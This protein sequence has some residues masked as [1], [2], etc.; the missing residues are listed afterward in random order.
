MTK[1]LLT[2]PILALLACDPE[3]D[4]DIEPRDTEVVATKIE[5]AWPI[6]KII[7]TCFAT[8]EI[9][10]GVASLEVYE[11]IGDEQAFTLAIRSAA[12]PKQVACVWNSLESGLP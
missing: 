1:L 3:A 2:L 12:T 7:L 5:S 10:G 4:G 9:Y 6:G 8:D 11:P